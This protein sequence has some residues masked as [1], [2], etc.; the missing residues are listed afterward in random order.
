MT[1]P[2][3]EQQLKVL[4]QTI[5][6]QAQTITEF[7]ALSDR[8][9][10]LEGVVFDQQQTIASLSNKLSKA[11]QPSAF[12]ILGDGWAV[13]SVG[14]RSANE[15]LIDQTQIQTGLLL[16]SIKMVQSAYRNMCGQ[17]VAIGKPVTQAEQMEIGKIMKEAGFA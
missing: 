5:A 12:Q 7:S 9:A 11:V 10:E 4:E 8:A 1:K 17:F 16:G 6:E 2:E 15:P 13:S 14:I 3:L